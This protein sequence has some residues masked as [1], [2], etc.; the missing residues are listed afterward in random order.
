[1]EVRAMDVGTVAAWIQLGLWAV[2]GVAVVVGIVKKWGKE[3]LMTLPLKVVYLALLF[4]L[5]ISATS[6]Y[7][8]YRPRIVQVDK[9]VEKPVERIVE[10]PI[11]QECQKVGANEKA[12]VE[13]EPHTPPK[14]GVAIQQS[15]S[16]G[17]NVQQATTG[18]N[19][20]IVNS[21]ITIGDVPKHISPGDMANLTNYLHAVKDKF[22]NVR[23]GVAADQYTQS[24]PFV[25]D[26]FKILSDAQLPMAAPGVQEIMVF[27]AHSSQK[28]KGVRIGVKG[29]PLKPGEGAN[30]APPDPLYYLTAIIDAL[31]LPRQLD[32]DRNAEAGVITLKFLGGGARLVIVRTERRV[33]K[34]SRFSRPGIYGRVHLGILR[35]PLF[36]TQPERFPHILLV[37]SRVPH[38]SGTLR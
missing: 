5:A 27:N 18:E 22:A 7:F 30:V 24:S 8:N 15:N 25:D 16:G 31:R 13:R 2:G 32:R 28:F 4:G 29:E 14:S 9:I 21:P 37:H 35:T 34:V 20:P 11:Q 19:S 10:K 33:P 17:L 23:V 1:M 6:L 36:I 26:F 38:S 3:G 12:P